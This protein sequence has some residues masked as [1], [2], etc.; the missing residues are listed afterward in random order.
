MN[1]K[2]LIPSWYQGKSHSP[3]RKGLRKYQ[4]IRYAEYRKN[5]YTRKAARKLVQPSWDVPLDH[6]AKVYDN[7]V[8]QG[9]ASIR[10]T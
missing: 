1:M 9:Y 2:S 10:R 5:G 3:P 4:K 8:F 7:G 6:L